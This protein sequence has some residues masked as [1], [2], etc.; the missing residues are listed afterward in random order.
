MHVVLDQVMTLQFST[1]LYFISIDPFGIEF[2]VI[3]S[4]KAALHI[5]VKGGLLKKLY[6]KLH[7]W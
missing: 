6:V 7:T 1:E 3:L 2:I 5:I 4:L